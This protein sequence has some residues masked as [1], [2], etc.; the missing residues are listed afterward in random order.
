MFPIGDTDVRE[1]GP[2]L[3]TVILVLL[4]VGVFAVQITLLRPG[5]TEFFNRYGVV[6]SRLVEGEQLYS[7]FTSMFIH[8]GWVHLITNM[9]FLWV[10]GDNVEAALGRIVYPLFYLGG[11]VAAM[12][13][14]VLVNPGSDL[15]SVGASGAIGA[16]LGA[17]I[18]MFPRAQVKVLLLLGFF[19]IVRRITAVVFLGVWFA[20]QFLTGLAGLGV[21]TAEAGGVAVWAHIGGFLFGVVIG[22]LFRDRAKD[23]TLEYER[24]HR[25]RGMV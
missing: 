18:V 1:A 23:L 12:A 9:L 24:Q 19:V 3:W 17:Y 10:F 2:G 21:E 15:P 14:H 25:R 22:F 4:N 11:G 7:V 6:P 8:G 5:L 16:L 13:A 20:M